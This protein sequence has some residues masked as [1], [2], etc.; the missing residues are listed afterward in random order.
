MFWETRFALRLAVLTSCLA[1]F[2]PAASSQVTTGRIEGFVK[3]PSGS[4]IPNAK[5]SLRNVDTNI[6]RR[7]D[8]GSDGA[9]S[10]AAVLP[11]NYELSADAP[12]FSRKTVTLAVYSNQTAAQD[13][14]LP[15]ASQSAVV[16]VAATADLIAT[17]AQRSVTR[18][19]TEIT[20]LPGR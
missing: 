1:L 11:G 5:V 18:I 9:Y 7:F 15:M 10:F 3:D 16:E 6:D 20:D 8:T 12:G 14:S 17:E 4:V 2:A 19:T 13:L